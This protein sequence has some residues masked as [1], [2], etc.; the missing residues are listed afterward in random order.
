MI[1]MLFRIGS[2]YGMIFGEFMIGVKIEVGVI[3]FR[4]IVGEIYF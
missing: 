3:K 2:F 4:V 1:F